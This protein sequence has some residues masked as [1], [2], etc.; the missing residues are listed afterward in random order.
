MLRSIGLVPLVFASTAWAQAGIKTLTA[1]L[2]P[3]AFTFPFGQREKP[4]E[5]RAA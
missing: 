2:A 3:S 5:A 4:L 1:H